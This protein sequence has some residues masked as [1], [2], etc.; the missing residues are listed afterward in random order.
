[1][2]RAIIGAPGAGNDE[3]SLSE[4]VGQVSPVRGSHR[5]SGSVIGSKCDLAYELRHGLVPP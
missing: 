1:V 5:Q 2:Q 4:E 3:P